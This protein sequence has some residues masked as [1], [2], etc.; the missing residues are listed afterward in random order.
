MGMYAMTDLQHQAVCNV[1]S[2]AFASVMATS[3]FLWF[4][5][6]AA[7]GHLKSGVLISGIVT[8][9]A[10]YHYTQEETYHYSVNKVD[11]LLS[12]VPFTDAHRYM[13]WLLTAPLLL[14][15]MLLV[16]KLS[17]ADYSTKTKNL[18]L[19][20]ALMIVSGYYGEMT[21][22]ADPTPRWVCWFTSTVFFL[23]IAYELLVGLSAAAEMETN[24]NTEG[25]LQAAHLVTVISWC[26]YSSV[27]FVG[28]VLF[29]LDVAR[30]IVSI[31]I[32]YCVSD[33]MSTCGLG[34]FVKQIT[35]AKSTEEG[36]LLC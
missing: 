30:A 32:G 34:V 19:G 21:V 27:M 35:Y 31:Q 36:L 14:I 26:T 10:A 5:S 20:T 22:V 9:I 3:L 29:G 8:F 28:F 1:S 7:T 13:D 23:Y 15:E 2:L 6:I 25:K 24:L 33:I 11:P 4:R 16:M 17:D 12:G 18:G